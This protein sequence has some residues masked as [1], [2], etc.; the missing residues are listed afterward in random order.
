MA[1][2]GLREVG[3][4]TLGNL[5]RLEKYGS[6]GLES[7]TTRSDPYIPPGLSHLQAQSC[8]PYNILE[9]LV[10]SAAGQDSNPGLSHSKWSILS[11]HH[12]LSLP[13][14]PSGK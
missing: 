7:L 9:R 6:A 4:A 13:Q 14:A 11:W 12:T 8:S 3:Q 2:Q 1:D 5:G 10:F